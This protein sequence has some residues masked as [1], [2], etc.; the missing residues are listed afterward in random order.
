MK[1]ASIKN[2]L[3]SGLML[4]VLFFLAQAALSWWVAERVKTDVVQTVRKNTLA[5][6]QLNELAVLAQ[7]IR[8]YEKEYF[9]YVSNAERRANY[10][11][12]WTETA[13][14]ITSALETMKTNKGGVFQSRDITQIGLWWAAGDF[15][16]SEMRKVFVSVTEQAGRV[17]L[18]QKSAEAVAPETPKTPAKQAQ[19]EL[20]LEPKPAMYS[21]GEANEMIKAGKDRFSNELIKGV[22]SLQ[23]EKTTATLALADVAQQGFLTMVLGVTA[24]AGIGILIALALVVWL[25]QSIIK[26]VSVLTAAVEKISLGQANTP[27]TN[28]RVLEFQGLTKAVERMRMAQEMMV[29]RMRQRS[30]REAVDPFA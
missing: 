6:A 7:Q 15:Y 22:A 10:E 16:A 29:N 9:V 12:E 5:A 26:P 25:P 28:V 13:K 24:T 17:A 14:K 4:I 27:L 19:P 8:R 1:T 30:A 20:P 18:A 21:P 11:K 23:A 3:T 2:R